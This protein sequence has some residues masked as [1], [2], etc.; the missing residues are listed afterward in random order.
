MSWYAIK[1]FFNR[2]ATVKEDLNK[3]GIKFYTQDVMPSLLFVDCD[4]ETILGIKAEKWQNLMVY[5][6]A[7]TSEPRA[8]PD[9]EMEI[10]ILVTSG[11]KDGFT[12][13][14]DDAP[15]Y[16]LGDRVRV[17]EGPFKG[18]EGHIKRIK[19]DRRLVITI[20]G[21]VAVA[22]AFIH[23]SLLEKVEQ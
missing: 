2:T 17:K 6:K 20:N 11:G 19:K 5:S 7:G 8:I 14:G 3:K 16:H 21:I 4:K 15:E 13:L 1:V 12:F 22:T 9:K 23:P 10:F 18:A